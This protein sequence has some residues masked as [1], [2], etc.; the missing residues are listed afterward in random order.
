M[1]R[2]LLSIGFYK[3]NFMFIVWYPNGLNMG[4]TLIHMEDKQH[5]IVYC[6][7]GNKK[8]KIEFSLADIKRLN[9]L[10][11]ELKKNKQYKST[12]TTVNGCTVMIINDVLEDSQ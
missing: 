7:K 2:F 1:K 4:I 9:Q 6:A 5:S 8:M 12:V 3:W 11:K 10:R